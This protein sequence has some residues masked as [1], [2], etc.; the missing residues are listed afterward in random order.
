M[1]VITE[2][3]LAESHLPALPSSART[4]LGTSFDPTSQSWSFQDGLQ[5]IHIDFEQPAA[6]VSPALLHSLKLVLLWYV[7]HASARHLMNMYA[8][9]LHLTRFLAGAR[10]EPVREISSIDLLNYRSSLA[11]YRAHYLGSLAG[12]LKKWYRLGLPGVTAEAVSLLDDLRIKGNEKGA[13]VVTMDPVH[14]PFTAIELESI[15]SAV[16]KAYERGLLS[17]EQYLLTWLFMALG[18]RPVQFAALKVC[19]VLRSVAE[20]GA[21]TYLLRVPRAKTAPRQ[22]QSRVQRAAIDRADR[23]ATL[24]LCGTIG[25]SLRGRAG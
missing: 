19:D 11:D 25:T 4:R 9:T 7:E 16:D 17:E 13:A 18:Q 6:V 21:V 22:S 14:G 3:R 24:R 5:W 2:Q 23:R 20:D 15:Q 12:F 10:K 1:A 8:R